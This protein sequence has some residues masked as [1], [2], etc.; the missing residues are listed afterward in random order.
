MAEV[1][2]LQTKAYFLLS[3]YGELIACHTDRGYLSGFNFARVGTRLNERNAVTFDAYS[4]GSHGYFAKLS[5]ADS[6]L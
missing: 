1:A 5:C 2:L 4:V 6:S 3:Y